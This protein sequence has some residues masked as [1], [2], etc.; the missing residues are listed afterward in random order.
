MED[1]VRHSDGALFN[2]ASQMW[3]HILYFFS[4]SPDGGEPP[5]GAL[6]SAINATWG[7][8]EAFQKTFVE[9]GTN[10]VGSGWV[11][12]VKDAAGALAIVALSNADNP[13][14]Y[15]YTPLL[16]FDVWEHAYY[17]DYKNLRADHLTQMW[18]LVSWERVAERF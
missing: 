3:S 13:L 8:F 17:L 7:S 4:L 1:I 2:N 9:A 6:A 10:L 18:Q 15:G 11:W 5:T 12:L 14:T 16:T